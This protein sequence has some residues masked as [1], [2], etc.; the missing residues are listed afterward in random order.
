MIPPGYNTKIVNFISKIENLS[1]TPDFAAKVVLNE[2]TGTIVMGENVL[3]STVAVSHGNL[4]VII[5]EDES[6]SQPLPFSSGRTAV[7]PES[8][9][10]VSEQ[11]S[12]LILLNKGINISDVIA[13]LN[14]IGVSPRD[15]IAILQAI[16]ASGALQAELVI[17]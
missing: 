15:L 4:S 1:V 5:K 17:I 2:R 14:A 10:E 8:E 7:V 3:I 6:V 13:A 12:E 9:V 16:K 11:K